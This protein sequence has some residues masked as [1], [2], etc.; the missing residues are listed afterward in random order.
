MLFEETIQVDFSRL[1]LAKSKIRL[2]NLDLKEFFC[3]K[4]L[5]HAEKHVNKCLFIK[6]E[7]SLVRAFFEGFTS[8]LTFSLPIVTS[9]FPISVKMFRYYLRTSQ[10]L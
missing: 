4:R 3:V 7:K 10:V 6:I 9:G 1:A 8:G 5:M 2:A